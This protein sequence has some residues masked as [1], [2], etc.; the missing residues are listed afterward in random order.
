MAIR[1]YDVIVSNIMVRSLPSTA[2]TPVGVAKKGEILEGEPREGW[3]LLLSGKVCQ[4]VF[5]GRDR[6]TDDDA[7][8]ETDEEYHDDDDDDDDNDDEDEDEDE[9]GD[10]DEDE[11]GGGCCC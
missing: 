4:A 7:E 9:D 2:A 8:A 11:V 10:G 1:R 3:L 5:G 6:D